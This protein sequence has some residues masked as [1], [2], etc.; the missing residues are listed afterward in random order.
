RERFGYEIE[1]AVRDGIARYGGALPIGAAIVVET[2]DPEVP[3]LI[4]APTM[5]VPSIVADTDNAYRAMRAVLTA[6]NNLNV[7]H[8]GA[9]E[10]IAIPGLC[11]GTGMMAPERAA[12]QMRLAYDEFHG[13]S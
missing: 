5:E 3:Y 11:T 2:E 13:E 6:A 1:D 9:I 4:S 7:R 8:P 12:R 10:T